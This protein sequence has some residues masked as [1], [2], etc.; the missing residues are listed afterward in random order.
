[1]EKIATFITTQRNQWIPLAGLLVMALALRTSLEPWAFMWLIALSVFFGCKWLTWKRALTEGVSTNDLRVMAYCLAWVGM[2]AEKFL[3]IDSNPA[4]PKLREWI[5]PMVYFI[6]G[7][8]LIWKIARIFYPA[9]PLL[10]GWL[11]LIGMGFLF[12]FG[13][14]QILSLFWRQLGVNAQPFLNS[15]YRAVSLA[16]FWG[17]RWNMAFRRLSHDFIFEPLRHKLNLSMAMF[18]TFLVSGL[19]LEAIISLPVN[20]GYGSPTLYFFLQWMGIVIERSK[21]GRGAGFSKGWR[22]RIF[23]IVFVLGPFYRLFHEPF[24]TGVILPFLRVIHSL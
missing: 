24:V 17:K 6:L 18:P 10:S 9:Y 16:D 23:T 15:P 11:G 12:H 4:K 8:I 5:M 3:D 14:F 7:V 21:R 2:D 22:G 20:A 19:L 13:S 1:M